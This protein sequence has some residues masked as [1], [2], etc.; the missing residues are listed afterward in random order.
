FGEEAMSP[1]NLTLTITGA[2]LL[3]V[4]WF[5]FNAGSAVAADS[6]AGLAMM[7]TQIATAMAA[8]TWMMAEWIVRGR[9]SAL[10]VVSGAVAGLVAI[11]PASGFVDASGALVIGLVAGVA[12]YLG[13]TTIK[14]I[15]GYDDSLDAFG[16]H[17]IGGA[18]GA[19]LTGVLALPQLA[20]GPAHLGVQALGIGVTAAFTA[21]M[22]WIIL[23]LINLMVGLRVDEET[24]V[25]GLDLVEHGEAL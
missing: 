17:G 1:H 24:E 19:L 12:C 10:G 6:R 9:P 20:G 3:W 18:V 16:I 22:T 13:A 11:T 23:Q 5:G 14:R 4:G 21:I 8:F 25:E 15:F 2:A 7:V